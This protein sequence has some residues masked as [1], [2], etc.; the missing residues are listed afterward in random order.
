MRHKD[1]IAH[2]H[3]HDYDGKNDHQVLMTGEIDIPGML[4]F[5]WERKARVLI[6]TKTAIS[7]EQSMERLRQA[8]LI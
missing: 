4:K 1:R 5:A 2:M 8:R 7:L 6:E 3:L